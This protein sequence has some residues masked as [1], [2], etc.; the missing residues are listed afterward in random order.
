MQREFLLHSRGR[1]DA[2]VEVLAEHSLSDVR[3]LIKEELDDDQLPDVD[4][5][6]L[7]DGT[8]IS[9]KQE[10]KKN[11]F[12]LLD[13]KAHVE[14]VSKHLKREAENKDIGNDCK[15]PAIMCNDSTPDKVAS[16]INNSEGHHA[17]DKDVNN[18][19]KEPA[20]RCNEVTPDNVAS[21]RSNSEGHGH[22]GA[23]AITPRTIDMSPY[24]SDTLIDGDNLS[25]D[26]D[27]MMV[28]PLIGA[29]KSED[30]EIIKTE[31]PHKEVNQAR[32]TS[33]Q[34]LYKMTKMLEENSDFCSEKRRRRFL[35]DIQELSD[36]SF[37]RTVFGVLGN[38]GV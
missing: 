20:T 37:P 14:M 27:D 38:T 2:Y 7:V 34:V 30:T 12:Q 19:G 15:K 22:I 23:A 31:D 11:A 29:G 24:V 10:A 21:S 5:A 18:D 35:A 9:T 4:F 17:E 13:T 1:E 6:F 25:D 8:R 26:L 16:A 36:T 28:I 3:E 32:E 33:L